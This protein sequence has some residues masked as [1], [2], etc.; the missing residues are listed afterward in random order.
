MLEVICAERCLTNLAKAMTV[1]LPERFLS[2][3]TLKVLYAKYL[4]LTHYLDFPSPT[5]TTLV[6]Q[7]SVQCHYLPQDTTVLCT[8]QPFPT[9]TRPARVKV[10][11]HDLSQITLYHAVV[12][13][14]CSIATAFRPLLGVLFSTTR[15]RTMLLYAT[16]H[17][18]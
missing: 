5:S 2:A 14:L 12:G 10:Q 18:Q 13:L 4:C 11:Y 17:Q 3:W 15:Q 7:I 6:P 1:P 16:V 8:P 9:S